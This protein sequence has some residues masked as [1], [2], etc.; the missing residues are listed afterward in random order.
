MFIK[1]QFMNNWVDISERI[2]IVSF[3]YDWIYNY[4]IKKGFY[5]SIILLNFELIIYFLNKKIK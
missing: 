3:T 5:I 1:Y 2:D 4:N